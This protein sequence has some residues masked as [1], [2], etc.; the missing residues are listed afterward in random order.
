[1]ILPIYLEPQ[2]ILRKK[3]QLVPEDEIVSDVFHQLLAD[4]TQTMRN[5]DGIGLAAPQVGIEKRFTV[6]DMVVA[7]QHATD[8]LVLINP[9]ITK[10]SFSKSAIE[11]GC[12]SI[13]GVY[14]TVKRS[15]EITVSFTNPQGQKLELKTDGL[16]A[17]VIQ[18]EVDHL[19]GIL[20]T[21]KIAKMTHNKRITPAYA[22]VA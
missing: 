6:I 22:H 2:P 13:P 12:L 1:M 14:G 15:K 16:L 5:A 3:T 11:E 17:I 10:R 21:D 8:V 18:H 4:M 7:D 19:D 20:F 9:K